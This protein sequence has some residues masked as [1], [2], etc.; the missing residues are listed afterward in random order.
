[1]E[2]PAT[3]SPA[4]QER[5]PAGGTALRSASAWNLILNL[6]SKSQ[7]FALL[8]AGS[9]IGGLVGV[10]VILT[11]VAA[12]V[13]GSGLASFGLGA[14]LSRLNVAYPS[15]HTVTRSVRSIFRQ[16]PLGLLFSPTAYLLVGPTKGS[17]ALLL[18][19]GLTS[20][21]LVA[22][23]ALTAILNGLGDFRSPAIRLGGA[24]L[25][26]S[27]G[28]VAVAVVKPDPAAVIGCF[29]GA[30]AFGVMALS[31]SVRA[32]RSRLPDVDHAK[33]HVQ[34]ARHWFGLAAVVS[35]LTNQADTLL[36]SSILSPESLGLFATASTLENGVATFAQAAT[37]PVA[38]RAIGATLAGD[39]KRGAHLTKRAFAVAVCAGLVLSAL[40][41]IVAQGAGD[42]I[43]KFE[44]LTHGDGPLV[45]GL[46]LLAG[47]P[48][49]VVAASLVFGAGYGRHRPVGIRQTLVGVCAVPAIVVGALVAGPVGAAAGTIV[50]DLAGVL[51]TRRLA[52]PPLHPEQSTADDA[53]AG[54]AVP[55]QGG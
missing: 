28:A 10:G 30:E 49:A 51:I 33:A 44:G 25:V 38:F 21:F 45:L 55:V 35:L 1:V 17:V 4:P 20:C 32:A 52:T 3:S 31:F 22:A 15:R 18:A 9:I 7:T 23:I 8:A 41:W 46:C 43:G 54:I 14:E 6:V 53:S 2:T 26:A 13:L 27:A 50:R 47:P 36:V 34:R 29:G 42:L 16:A 37:T 12:C 39:A 5:G 19:I 24:R 48:G 40:A 11:A